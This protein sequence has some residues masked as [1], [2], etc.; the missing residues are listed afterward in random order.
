MQK[1]DVKMPEKLLLT[2]FCGQEEWSGIVPVCSE[3]F[4]RFPL[5]TNKLH[6]IGNMS[7]YSVLL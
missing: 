1:A 3:R 2:F 6:N 5:L 7:L 4:F